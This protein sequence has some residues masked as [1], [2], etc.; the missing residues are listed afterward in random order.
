MYNKT[1]YIKA[2][3]IYMN[4][5]KIKFNQAKLVTNVINLNHQLY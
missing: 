3:Y 2:V 1:V 5:E 4:N